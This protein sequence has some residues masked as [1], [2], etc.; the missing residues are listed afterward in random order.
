MNIRPKTIFFIV[1]AAMFF[2]M[3]AGFLASR[4]ANEETA[5]ERPTH[6]AKVK[7]VQVSA[8]LPDEAEANPDAKEKG[9]GKIYRI[10]DQQNLNGLTVKLLR[11]REIIVGHIKASRGKF[12]GL[13]FE[14]ANHGD[15]EVK[16]NPLPLLSLL[17]NDEKQDLALIETKGDISRLLKPGEK[18]TGEVAFDSAVS[19]HYI[20][21]FKNPLNE[22]ISAVWMFTEKDIK[23]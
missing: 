3:M 5:K 16:I 4:N 19:D 12:I 17:A 11:V 10:G 22:N 9:K 21:D 14:I 23:K 7:E 8:K 20:V 18:M 1:T 13:E 15:R 6:A 2:A